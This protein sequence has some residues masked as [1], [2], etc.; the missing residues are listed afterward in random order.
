[1]GELLR[2]NGMLF[3]EALESLTMTANSILGTTTATLVG[4]VF[5]FVFFGAFYS[6][7][8]EGNGSS[9]SDCDTGRQ[10][11]GPA[12]ASVVSSSISISGSA[13]PT[14]LPP[15][16][17]PFRCCGKPGRAGLIPAI[18]FYLSLSPFSPTSHSNFPPI[19]S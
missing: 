3:A 6:A 15:V 1:M 4:L 19:S 5:Y 8:G 12:K 14:L 17:S 13:L 2:G 7:I 18:G 16:F 11:S 10:A 9:I